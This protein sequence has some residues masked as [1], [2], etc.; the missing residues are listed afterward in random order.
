MTATVLAALVEEGKLSWEAT[1]EQAFR[2]LRD[3]MNPAYRTVTL[4]QLLAHRAGFPSR[5][6][7]E[8]KGFLAM[9]RLPGTPREQRR[10][11]LAAILSERPAAEPGTKYLY[12]NRSYVV[13]G[14]IAEEIMNDSWEDLMRHRIFEPL[15]MTTAGF[16]AMGT[17]G[18]LDQPWQHK[19]IWKWH[20]AI[21]PG[22]C[23][24]NPRVIAPAGEAHCSIVDWAKFIQAH[25][26]GEQG[27]SGILKPETFKRLHTA[28]F[29]GNYG[30]G[31]ITV[32]RPWAGGRALTH[33]GSNTLNYAV[34]W[35]A[36]A[37]DFAVLVMTN[38]GGG[39]TFNACDEAATALIQ[40][41][42]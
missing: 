39:N 30:F 32:D 37:K 18:K 34:A 23:A 40:E 3:T 24:G 19:L 6:W 10:T 11:Y 13:A 26:R 42:K 20:W 38:Q 15:G 41:I 22:P 29:D 17:P 4:E 35:L 16:G 14:A 5:S 33:G 2:H 1:L 27:E 8:G 36:P 31:W 9:H 25:L 7:P 12:S 21:K 28:P